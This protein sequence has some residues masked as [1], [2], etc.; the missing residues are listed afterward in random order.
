MPDDLGPGTQL[1][2][3]EQQPSEP[4]RPEHRRLWREGPPA[5]LDVA[6]ARMYLETSAPSWWGTLRWGVPKHD[7]VVVAC[8][9]QALAPLPQAMYNETGHRCDGGL[10]GNVHGCRD[11]VPSRSTV[12]PGRSFW[13]IRSRTIGR[14]SF[15]VPSVAHTRPSTNLFPNGVNAV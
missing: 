13:S 11:G 6:T 2:F 5:P 9:T 10:C 12:T 8:V 7:Q 15:C 14:S 1:A 3:A 4:P